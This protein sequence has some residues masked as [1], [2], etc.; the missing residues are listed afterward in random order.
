MPVEAPRQD[1]HQQAKRRKNAAPAHGVDRARQ[2]NDNGGHRERRRKIFD[3]GAAVRTGLAPGHESLDGE[4]ADQTQNDKCDVERD[5]PRPEAL[6]R[7]VR[8]IQTAYEE[9]SRKDGETRKQ[10]DFR[11]FHEPSPVTY[12]MMPSSVSVSR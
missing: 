9:D 1:D 3:D 7:A 10:D 4:D 6:L 8:H 2:K 11:Q 5:I 12:L